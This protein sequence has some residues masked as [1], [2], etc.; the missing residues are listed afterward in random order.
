MSWFTFLGFLGT[1][2]SDCRLVR[3]KLCVNLNKR[4]REGVGRGGREEW[5]RK[6][7]EGQRRECRG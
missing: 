4:E 3:L 6:E 2:E 7:R 1:M 5:E